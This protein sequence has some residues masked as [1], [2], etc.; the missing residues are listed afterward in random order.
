[1]KANPYAHHVNLLKPLIKTK[2]T[3]GINTASSSSVPALKFQEPPIPKPKKKPH[4]YQSYPILIHQIFDGFAEHEQKLRIPK[5]TSPDFKSIFM[6]KLNVSEQILVNKDPNQRLAKRIAL[7]QILDTVLSIGIGTFLDKEMQDKLFDVIHMNIVRPVPKFDISQFLNSDSMCY[8]IIEW[9]YLEFVYMILQIFYKNFPR[10]PYFSKNFFDSIFPLISSKDRSER[11]QIATLFTTYFSYNQDLIDQFIE[12]SK[13]LIEMHF[14]IP[15]PCAIYTILAIISN[16]MSVSPEIKKNIIDNSMNSIIMLIR[17]KYLSIFINPLSTILKQILPL[18]KDFTNEI[19]KS[20]IKYWPYSDPSKQYPMI[21]IAICAL[22]TEQATDNHQVLYNIFK[23]ISE[24]CDN[25]FFKVA[26][27]ACKCFQDEMIMNL[28]VT[29]VPELIQEVFSHLKSALK[30]WSSTVKESAQISVKIM[31]QYSKDIILE[32]KN[33]SGKTTNWVSIARTAAR[34]DRTINLTA[35]L[36]QL[37]SIYQ[38]SSIRTVSEAEKTEAIS[39][40]QQKNRTL[41]SACIQVA[42]AY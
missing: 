31:N 24:L 16:L 18:S 22:R 29:F 10:L 38:S 15:D 21:N 19:L 17:N 27:Q 2:L 7:R 11:D 9:E 12:K 37:S 14:E 33:Y 34:N 26:D 3:R 28:L 30:H 23:H 42:N 39:L 36:G 32:P 6:H 41:S 1:M 13:N 40:L 8:M 35:K 25:D 5:P 4:V 20:V